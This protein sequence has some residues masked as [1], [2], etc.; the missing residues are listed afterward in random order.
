[1]IEHSSIIYLLWATIGY[2]KLFT[3]EDFSVRK[4]NI[5][6]Q[7]KD[8]ESGLLRIFFLT[9]ICSTVQEK[10]RH[11]SQF[12]E[13]WIFDMR[14]KR[15]QWIPIHSRLLWLAYFVRSWRAWYIVSLVS[16]ALFLCWEDSGAGILCKCNDLHGHLA[17]A[18]A[19]LRLHHYECP[20]TQS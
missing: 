15:H 1:M 10:E 2:Q 19:H 9:K 8:D 4:I 13:N 12:E 17:N 7:S 6:W 16:N 14:K 20:V 18:Q 11:D 3:S 5:S